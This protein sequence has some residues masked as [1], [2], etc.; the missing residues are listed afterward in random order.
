MTKYMKNHERYIRE[1]LKNKDNI[2]QLLAYHLRQIS[3]LQ[4]ERLIHLCV[5]MLVT[6]IFFAC[7]IF[8][9]F[10]TILFINLLAVILGVLEMF[11]LLHYFR[12]ENTVQRWYKIANNMM[13]L[14]N[15]IATNLYD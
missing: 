3:W 6:L 9:L 13:L 8:I 11:Y 7:V 5:L 1:Q 15:G 12:L 4:H 10:K 14:E 2:E